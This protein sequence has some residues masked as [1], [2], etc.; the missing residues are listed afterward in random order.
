MQEEILQNTPNLHVIEAAIEDMV[1]D[2]KKI[3]GVIT[4]KGEFIAT[5]AVVITT[6]TFLRGQINIGLDII[7][8]GRIGDPPAIGLANTLNR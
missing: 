6:G 1:V 8:A 3:V 2:H 4:S 7:P 5:K